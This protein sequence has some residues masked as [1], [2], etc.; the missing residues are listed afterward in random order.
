MKIAHAV[1]AASGIGVAGAALAERRHRQQLRLRVAT[2]H[3]KW[4]SDVAADADLRRIWSPPG[5]DVTD[6]EHLQHLC[7]N[8]LLSFLSAKF[9]AGLLD[10]HGLRMQARWFM[11]REA[12]R[13][14]W[15]LFAGQ[16][17]DEETGRKDRYFNSVMRDE[18]SL[19][20]RQ[21]QAWDDPDPLAV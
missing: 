7:C 21:D 10:K 20:A 14:Y 17:E 11:E 8:R 18:Y 9:H 15:K 6:E 2:L 19:Y 5:G 12:A 4:I 3:Q 16:R 13:N 1:L